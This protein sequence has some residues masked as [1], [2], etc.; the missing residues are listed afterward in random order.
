MKIDHFGH[1]REV[2]PDLKE[3]GGV[4]PVGVEQGEHLGVHDAL[5]GRHP[6]RIAPAVSRRRA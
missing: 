4:G 3:L 6:L 1:L 5:S 2:Q